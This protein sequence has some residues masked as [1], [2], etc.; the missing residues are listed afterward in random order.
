MSKFKNLFAI[1]GLASGLFLAGCNP[2]NISTDTGSSSTTNSSVSSSV[3]S[4]EPEAEME[5]TGTKADPYLPLTAKHLISL[6]KKVLNTEPLYITLSKDIDLGNKEWAPLGSDND[7]MA[8]VVFNGMGHTVKGLKISESTNEANGFY[9]FFGCATGIVYDLNIE[10]DITI[11][12]GNSGYA[13][14]GLLSGMGNNLYV[15]NVH[16]K[17][18]LT[19]NDDENQNSQDS[20]AGGLV[21]YFVSTGNYYVSVEGS[22][23]EGSVISNADS[24]GVAGGLIGNASTSTS[25]IGVSALTTNQVKA[26]TISAT[27][28][29]GGIVGTS[30]YYFSAVNNIVSADRIETTG[31]LSNYAYAGG[32]V[33]SN[34][35]ENAFLYNIVKA[36]TISS[37]TKAAK[38]VAGSIIA[39]DTDDGYANGTNLLGSAN[40][41][42]ILVTGTLEGN[43]KNEIK[44]TPLTSLTASGLKNIGFVEKAWTL[45]DGQ[46]PIVK[47]NASD[48]LVV[49]NQTLTI[50]ANYEGG[51]DE[52]FDFS[53]GTM[54]TKIQSKKTRENYTLINSSY[55][56][57][58]LIA[59]R[60]YAP[61]NIAPTL[62]NFWFD[63]TSI[64]G[65]WAGAD[66]VNFTLN[67]KTD[68]TMT[69]YFSDYD[70]AKGTWWSNGKYLVF[71]I[72][73]PVAPYTNQ[74]AE[75]KTDGTFTF[76]DA[77]ADEYTYTYTKK[78]VDFG[79][80]GDDK[81][82]VLTLNGDGTGTYTD[83]E[84]L[85]KVTYVK[86]EGVIKSIKVGN[87]ESVVPTIEGKT[88]K[89]TL[90]DDDMGY[91][92]L[93]L[94]PFDGIPDY[95][96]WKL[97][98]TYHGLVY[99]TTFFANGNSE[100][101]QQKEGAG[102]YSYGGFRA[103]GL[104]N[105]NATVY[106]KNGGIYTK[107]TYMYNKA[108]EVLVKDDGSDILVK[109]GTFQK[110]YKNS[111]KTVNIYQF[112]NKNYLVINGKLDTKT[113]ITGTLAEGE[114]I[115]IGTDTYTITKGV[116]VYNDPL[117]DVTA[118]V[119]TYVATV[120]D[121]KVEL[122]LNADRTGTY[123]ST[124]INYS[125]DG[126]KVTFTVNSKEVSLAFNATD[127][128]LIGTMK[129]GETTTDL[130]FKVKTD[131][132][133][134]T[135]NMAGTWTGKFSSNTWTFTVNS[136]NTCTMVWPAA[137]F[138]GTWTGD[139]A[140]KITVNINSG[141][142]TGD[143]TYNSA[144]D[145]LSCSL[146]DADYNSYNV[147]FT[148]VA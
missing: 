36:G 48:D 134:E 91:F 127:K 41:G 39:S 111:S 99:D 133:V 103:Y 38:G 130:S 15:S 65:F 112:T 124:A 26:T 110:A 100:S 84:S 43:T 60:W 76:P 11:T 88:I 8:N 58:E 30:S 18:N 116:L 61:L 125:Y 126:T 140:K 51:E 25:S 131:D 74:V 114:T 17:G 23:F 28:M 135:K 121:K 57:T 87:Y 49:K 107:G 69:T 33:G 119:N 89:M 63:A 102:V 123:D 71:T 81:G 147:S 70:T 40:Y 145:T 78:A 105:G 62:Y 148:R 128:T 132:P 66:A 59:Y 67:I 109:N 1:V 13:F 20:F 44:A 96:D 37:G 120:G 80:W 12:Q 73:Y 142:L 77:N 75:F 146:E 14:A 29:A 85:I 27:L 34:Y 55:S 79:Y 122:V 115:T 106:F 45:E 32:V 139:I 22:S 82:H 53:L 5:G 10:G 93:T 118:L 3:S 86:T 54:N 31:A 83:G 16:T 108:E 24:Y 4:S 104:K 98:G 52:T 9:G 97:L 94:S 95:T 137:T 42:N 143:F 92:E 101:R 6:E 7:H 50:K 136:D 47:D 46:L 19:V 117:P 90:G 141:Y 56:S 113:T 129:E 2:S 72:D 64:E 68:G 35:Y 138:N 144:N 21:G